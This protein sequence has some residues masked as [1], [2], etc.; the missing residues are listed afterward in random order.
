MKERNIAY[1]KVLQPI[2]TISMSDKLSE[3]WKLLK[4]KIETEKL[5]S[6]KKVYHDMKEQLKITDLIL[7]KIKLTFT[8]LTFEE[9]NYRSE[10]DLRIFDL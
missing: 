7:L 9:K 4:S 6:S 8:N 5:D 3:T 1:V 2:E 10:I